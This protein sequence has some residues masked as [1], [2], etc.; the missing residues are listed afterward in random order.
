[1]TPTR[2]GAPSK[3][4]SPIK[5]PPPSR[6]PVRKVDISTP[7]A[8]SPV[9]TS[10]SGLRSKHTLHK[11]ASDRVVLPPLPISKA[12]FRSADEQK[13]V[14]VLASSDDPSLGQMESSSDGE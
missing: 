2:V 7:T 13:Q 10:K 4:L 14:E 11:M 5:T 6:I 1:M 9:F 12:E 8:L 3:V